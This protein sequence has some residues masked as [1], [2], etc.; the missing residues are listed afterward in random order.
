MVGEGIVPRSRRSMCRH[1]P[2]GQKRQMPVKNQ[3]HLNTC[4]GPNFV[5][6]PPK[7]SAKN[8][9]P[10]IVPINTGPPINDRTP[11]NC[12]SVEESVHAAY[13]TMYEEQ[14]APTHTHGDVSRRGKCAPYIRTSKLGITKKMT[15]SVG[16]LISLLFWNI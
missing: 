6:K 7:I 8:P 14:F 4:Q 16:E 3:Q 5:R 12:L 1:L 15:V 9:P 10:T 13:P 11:G 2:R